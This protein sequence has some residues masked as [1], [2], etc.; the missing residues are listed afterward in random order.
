[1][2]SS[3]GITIFANDFDRNKVFIIS[4]RGR[5]TTSPKSPTPTFKIPPKYYKK[6]YLYRNPWRILYRSLAFNENHE[7]HTIYFVIKGSGGKTEKKSNRNIW[8]KAPEIGT[9]S[10]NGDEI[11][12]W[13]WIMLVERFWNGHGSIGSSADWLLIETTKWL[14]VSPRTNITFWKLIAF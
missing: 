10:G 7:L 12:K 6:V 8:S 9:I 4:W 13:F 14:W 1:M 2:S 3:F 5:F 11:Y